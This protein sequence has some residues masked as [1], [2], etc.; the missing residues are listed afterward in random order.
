MVQD[1]WPTLA[2]SLS[3]IPFLFFAYP[4]HCFGLILFPVLPS[5]C[6]VLQWNWCL[7]M[8]TCFPVLPTPVQCAVHTHTPDLL[9]EYMGERGTLP[10]KTRC[11]SFGYQEH[12]W[13]TMRHLLTGTAAAGHQ[14]L[15]GGTSICC[16]S[17]PI[18]SATLIYLTYPI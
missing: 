12:C 9:T 11:C 1:Q 5:Y 14:H 17:K 6:P 15:T 4:E 7:H 18:S 16:R 2:A 10:R 3:L 8:Q 13:C